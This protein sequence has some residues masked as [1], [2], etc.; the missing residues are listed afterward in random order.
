MITTKQLA[1]L[2]ALGFGSDIAK[3]EDYVLLMQDSAADGEP[4]VED[5]VY[6]QHIR[7]LK[8]LKPDS[9]AFTRNWEKDFGDIDVN[10]DKYL[11]SMGMKSITT[12]VNAKELSRVAQEHTKLGDSLEYFWST[13]LNGHAFRA[14]YQYGELTF[15]TLRG[16]SKVGREIT[17]HLKLLL[18]NKVEAWEDVAL[19]EVRGELVVKKSVFREKLAGI[20]KSPLASIT[21]ISRDSA[22]DE[23]IKLINAVC[24]KMFQDNFEFDTLE[25]EFNHLEDCGFEVAVH[26]KETIKTEPTLFATTINNLVE[27]LGKEYKAEALT[28]YDCDGLVVAINNNKKFYLLGPNKNAWWGNLAVKMGAWECSHYISTVEEIEWCY[29]KKWITPKAHIKPTL[30]SSGQTVSVVPLYTVGNLVKLGLKPGATIHFRFGGE[31]GVQLLTPSG[32]SVTVL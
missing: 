9:E 12:C 10:R 22:P 19:T 8:E 30:T 15:G 16:R 26:G 2:E 6:D 18:P 7:L 13:K 28:T 4:L 21:S 31:T 11:D 3:L 23:E 20:R 29:G 25:D 24:Y 14:V 17:R 27:R 32:E 1:Q 5:S